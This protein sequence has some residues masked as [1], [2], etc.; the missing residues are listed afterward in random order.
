MT[1]RILAHCLARLQ[2]RPFL[3]YRHLTV[4]MSVNATIFELSIIPT[5]GVGQKSIALTTIVYA[6]ESPSG[7]IR[8]HTQEKPYEPWKSLVD[9]EFAELVLDKNLKKEQVEFL[10][11]LINRNGSV[12]SFSSYADIE[13]GWEKAALYHPKV[14]TIFNVHVDL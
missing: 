4:Q 13:K 5:V 6:R 14:C 12:L 1:L 3:G 7:P 2:S 10:L 11:S 9:F 8:D